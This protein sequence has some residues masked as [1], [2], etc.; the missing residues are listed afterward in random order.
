MRGDI[1]L[2]QIIINNNFQQGK[3]CNYHI[4][5]EA[6]YVSKRAGKNQVNFTAVRFEN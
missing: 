2:C 3:K 1:I 6:L 4:A 5:D